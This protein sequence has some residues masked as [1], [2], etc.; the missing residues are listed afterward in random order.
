M[1]TEKLIRKS[2]T[3]GSL[4]CSDHS[5][6]EFMVMKETGLVKGQVRTLNFKKTDLLFKFP[7]I[8]NFKMQPEQ[9]GKRN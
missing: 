2:K 9:Q 8:L 5:L 4:C 7:L 1:N 3:G 6:V